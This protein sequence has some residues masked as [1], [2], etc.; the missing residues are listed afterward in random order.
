MVRHGK[1]SMTYLSNSSISRLREA[2]DLP[3]LGGTKYTMVRRIGRGG[4]GTV[5]LVQDGTLLRHVAMKVL[6]TAIESDDLSTRLH[7]EAMI[8]AK[9]EHPGIVPIHD[10]GN[11]PDG[12]LY[13]TMKFVQGSQLDHY[14]TSVTSIPERLRLF[15]KICE[16]VAFAHSKK[17]IHRDL[18][19]PNIM[20]GSFGEVLVMDWGVAK[21]LG[22]AE[23]AAVAAPSAEGTSTMHGTVIG[24]P[25][26]MSP[27]QRRG[28]TIDERSD[29]YALGAILYFLL[30]D[31]Q[32]PR[33][34]VQ[35]TSLRRI[36]PGVEKSIEAVCMKV[37]SPERDQRYG[38]VLDLAADIAHLIDGQPVSAYRETIFERADRWISRNKLLVV[39]ILAY[40]LMR[41]LLLFMTGH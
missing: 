1:Q 32:P 9:L 5:Y 22:D 26:Y 28:E 39:L 19:P 17:I 21:A 20:V 6:D 25:A 16:P 8:V 34:G 18:K 41:M 29:V 36:N 23:N 10:I 2:I 7:R 12:R 27:E 15:Q 35:G 14:T 13:Y 40:L 37:L 31:Q 4:M 3:D 24:T 33:A 38:S 11:L 30:T